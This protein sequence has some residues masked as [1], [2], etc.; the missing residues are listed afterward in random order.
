MSMHHQP[1]ATELA[2]H[3]R[4]AA[5][6]RKIAARA[7]SLL[8]PPAPP[9]PDPPTLSSTAGRAWF[10]DAWALLSDAAAGKMPLAKIK[11]AVCDHYGVT[12]N[13]LISARRTKDIIIPRQVAVYLCKEL[14][15]STLPAIGRAFGGRDHTTQLSSIRKITRLLPLDPVLAVSIAKIKSDLA[16]VL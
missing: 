1:T 16:A 10:G 12:M 6:H 7:T 14:T 8:E 11:Q 2:V 4:H 9:E 13:D 5:F 3:A 15:L